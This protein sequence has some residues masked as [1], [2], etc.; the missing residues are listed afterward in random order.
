MYLYLRYPD[1]NLNLRVGWFVVK[2]KNEQT[3]K[4]TINKRIKTDG[5]IRRCS[6]RKDT[7]IIYNDQ[8]GMKN[9]RSYQLFPIDTSYLGN[10]VL[11]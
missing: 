5:G 8:F 3:N 6:Y 4:Q 9:A 7:S 2:E 11:S 10:T 1:K